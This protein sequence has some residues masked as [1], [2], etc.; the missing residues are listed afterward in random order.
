MCEIFFCGNS[1]QLLIPNCNPNDSQHYCKATRPEI[2]SSITITTPAKCPD[3]AFFHYTAPIAFS[4]ALTVRPF[5]VFFA[6]L[7]GTKLNSPTC[8]LV[9][10][11]VAARFLD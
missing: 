7:A 3:S 4:V 2:Y 11:P 8:S 6:G 1:H 9:E 10:T 5:L